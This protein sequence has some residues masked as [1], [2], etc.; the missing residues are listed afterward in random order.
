MAA[1]Y[2]VLANGGTYMKPYIVERVEFPEKK[3]ITYHPE[4]VRRVIKES[5]SEQITAML[6]EGV[7]EGFAKTGGVPGFDIAGKTG[8]SQIAK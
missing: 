5:T 4:P 3:A 7:R 2:G 8:T 1:A 6:V